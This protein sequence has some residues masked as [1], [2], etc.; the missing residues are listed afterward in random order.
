MPAVLVIG[1]KGDK[2]DKPMADEPDGDETSSEDSSSRM[3]ARKEAAKAL[4]RAVKM[5]DADALDKALEAHYQACESSGEEM[6]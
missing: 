5:S 4:I 3:E 2:G 1:G 6:E